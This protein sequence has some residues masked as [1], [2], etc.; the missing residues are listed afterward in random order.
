MGSLGDMS[1][2]GPLELVYHVADRV[3]G[4]T[5][6][7]IEHPAAVFSDFVATVTWSESFIQGL[8]TAQV[9]ILLA[10]IM[11]RRKMV[12]QIVIF[13]LLSL[14]VFAA[15]PLN[16]W[17]RQ[18]W[19]EFATQ[20]YFDRSGLFAVIFYAGPLLLSAN[21]ILIN[22]CIRTAKIA[23]RVQ[24]AKLRAAMANQQSNGHSKT[25]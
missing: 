8:I 14:A 10:V 24:R 18:H 22:I 2:K 11:T 16:N 12:A 21:I 4:A 20:N 1:E 17:C 25:E 19:S 15:E 13:V 5:Q 3:L 7:Q 23:I 6:K 9:V